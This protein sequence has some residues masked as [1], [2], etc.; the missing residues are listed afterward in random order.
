MIVTGTTAFDAQD[1]AL[2]SILAEWTSAQS[3][4]VR[5]ANINGTGKGKTFDSRLNC[6]CFLKSCGAD[7]TVFD[8]GS[9]DVVHDGHGRDWNFT[10]AGDSVRGKKRSR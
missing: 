3:L 8:D 10:G 7:A 1:A 9:R 4:S 2:R 5:V 6:N